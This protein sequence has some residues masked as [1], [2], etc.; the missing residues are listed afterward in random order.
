MST[1]T[2]LGTWKLENRL[3]IL[4]QPSVISTPYQGPVRYGFITDVTEVGITFA[5]WGD[6]RLHNGRAAMKSV[7]ALPQEFLSWS[8]IDSIKEA[9][10]E[11]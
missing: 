1:N 5:E 3:V 7:M 10:K 9:P 11:E 4:Q 8:V 6:E 2:C